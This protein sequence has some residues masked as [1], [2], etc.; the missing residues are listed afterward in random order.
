MNIIMTDLEIDKLKETGQW[1]IPCSDGSFSKDV[2]FKQFSREF[3]NL[4]RKH[5]KYANDLKLA[6]NISLNSLNSFSCKTKT[7][8]DL[9]KKDYL[10]QLLSILNLLTKHDNRTIQDYYKFNLGLEF[11]PQT[12]SARIK[13][14]EKMGAVE[15]ISER[16]CPRK[17]RINKLSLG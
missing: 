3:K 7:D 12:I 9:I 2:F 10:N 6:S 14:L 8:Y 11:S 16:N 15:V 17:L 13:V 1:T 5:G 4:Y